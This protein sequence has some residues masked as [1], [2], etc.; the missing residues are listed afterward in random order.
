MLKTEKITRTLTQLGLTVN[1]AKTYL[2]L[3]K[4]GPTSAKEI[5]RISNI[6][7]QD[8]YRVMPE[9]Q[10]LG[11]AE[12][13]IASPNLFKANPPEQ[14]L[15]A[16][17]ERREKE[18]AV[19]HEEA[20]ELVER[21]SQTLENVKDEQDPSQFSIISGKKTI[22]MKSRK[23]IKVAKAS[24]CVLAPWKNSAKNTRHFF[25]ITQQALNRQVE[26][27]FILYIDEKEIALFSKIRRHLVDDSRFK[28][29]LVFN[30]KPISFSI[31]DRE[32][33]FPTQPGILGDVPILWSNNPGFADFAQKYFDLLWKTT[34]DNFSIDYMA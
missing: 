15:T 13:L 34:S 11:L 5:S 31:I 20:R 6:A 7:Q 10:K 33:F 22:L 16:L 12:K 21:L 25:T 17:V 23:A 9:L 4:L 26:T 32:V 1:Q 18:N 27:R 8:I 28:L 30:E 14:A 3:V 29:K 24:I 19:L 2:S